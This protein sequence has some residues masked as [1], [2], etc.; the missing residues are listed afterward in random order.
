[1]NTN[2]PEMEPLD[3]DE[4]ALAR[5]VRALPAG[6]PPSALDARILK[7]ASDALATP[8]RR[9]A[10][11]LTSSGSLWGIGS[12]AAAVLVLGIAWQRMNPPVPA[13]PATAPV[14]VAQDKR[15]DGRTE[16]EFKTEA[17]K[18]Y[19]NS[20]PPPALADAPRP[21]AL[22]PAAAAAP[23]APAPFP[24][25]ALKE[26]LDEHVT[27]AFARGNAEPAATG[28]APASRAEAQ[29]LQAEAAAD[30]AIAKAAAP[31]VERDQ[32]ASGLVAGAKDRVA[33]DAKLYPESWL[34]KIRTRLK[35]G[36]TAGARAS[37]H[38]YIAKYPN[39]VIP[40]DL[41]V[42]LRE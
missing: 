2:R 1:M 22:A 3:D 5:I 21:R 8:M 32:A 13:L 23:A 20:P 30:N 4:Q 38:L 11:W 19:D 37:L 16:V 10:V 14:T 26:R 27:E 6:E 24:Q 29:S 9:R 33:D 25:D 12:A 7:A 36:D 15:D 34:A 39:Q 17:P 41:K 28:G 42:L 31:A 40:D 18:Q 35:H